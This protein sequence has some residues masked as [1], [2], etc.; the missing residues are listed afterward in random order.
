MQTARASPSVHLQVLM[1]K[2]LAAAAPVAVAAVVKPRQRRHVDYPDA[3]STPHWPDTDDESE[4]WDG[5]LTCTE[6]I[7]HFSWR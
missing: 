6:V 2:S 5:E 1:S 7:T 3:D 4:S